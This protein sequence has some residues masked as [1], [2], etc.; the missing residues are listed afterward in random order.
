MC[1]VDGNLA[2]QQSDCPFNTVCT[3]FVRLSINHDK[4]AVVNP[5]LLLLDGQQA[6][7]GLLIRLV[8]ILIVEWVE[9][10]GGIIAPVRTGAQSLPL[11]VSRLF[12]VRQPTVPLFTLPP[13]LPLS[14]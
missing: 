11:T 6:I 7:I 9:R 4:R 13:R 14:P 8:N 1:V 5:F 12:R 10:T 2:L 3:H